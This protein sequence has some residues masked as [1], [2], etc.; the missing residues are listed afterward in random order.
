MKPDSGHI[1]TEK[2]LAQ[3]EKEVTAIY[4]QAAKETTAKLED[5]FRRFEIKD[6]R[7]KE[8]V[9]DGTKTAKQYKEWRTG[10]ML[11]GRRWE[12]MR[13]QL[14]RDVVQADKIARSALLEHRPDIYAIN[15]NYATYEAEHGL[16]V[17]TSYT[18]YDRQTVERLISK[19]PK[20]LPDPT[21][22]GSVSR[23]IREGRA[24][25]WSRQH[26]QSALLQGILQGE[27]IPNLTRRL[28]G[29]YD[30]EHRAAIRYA[31]TMTTGAESAGRID[32]Y[33]RAQDL[34][35][36]LEQ[37]WLAILDNRTRHS[38]RLMDGQHVPVG[39]VFSNGCEYPGDPDGPAEEVWNC[40]CTLIAYLKGFERDLSY[41][42]VRND[43]SLEGMSYD[44]WKKKHGE[45]QRITKQEEKG[46]AIR[47]SYIREY[48]RKR[49]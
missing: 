44:E 12:R 49:K 21:P 22:N 43:K 24:I 34:G 46:E 32:G 14:A 17:N 28:E 1:E 33:R 39:E 7:W 41:L 18:L 8:W 15:H 11:M 27:S 20:L 38:H 6:E 16:G 40:R 37:Q 19:N 45:S 30:M 23:A 3:M 25:R 5:Y 35:I 13:D 4:N 42:S 36:E 48:R 2:L 31:R 47:Q 29:V 26:I 9:E 10:Q